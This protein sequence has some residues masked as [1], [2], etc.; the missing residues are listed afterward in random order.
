[1]NRM[2]WKTVLALTVIIPVV[3]GCDL[4]SRPR[5]GDKVNER[6]ETSN[7]VF[8]VRVT[9]YAEESAGFVGGAYYVFESASVESDNWREIMTFRHDDPIPIPRDQVQFLGDKTAYVF[10]GWMY[11]VTTDGGS[12]WSLWNAETELPKW[13][14]CNYKLIRNVQIRPNGVGTM[15]LDPIPE[16]QGEVPE[17]HTKDY[18]FNWAAN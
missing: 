2:F 6:W 10:M 7:E 1:M 17:L 9:S 16:R 15:R 11:A 14:C 12:A 3:S 5:R 13:K 8:K 4:L 18:G